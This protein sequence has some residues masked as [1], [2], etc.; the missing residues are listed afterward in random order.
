MKI[1]S[2]IFA[3]LSA[4]FIMITVSSPLTAQAEM[5][6][7]TEITITDESF[8]QTTEAAVSEE[9][10]IPVPD[11]APSFSA[12]VEYSSMGYVV[13]GSFTEFP[14]DITQVFP[15]Y[16][17]DGETWQ[18]C[19]EELAWDLHSLD[20]E[21]S[22]ELAK[23]QNQICLYDSMEPLNSYL[24]GAL[25]CFYIKLRLTKENGTAYESQ[26]AVITRENPQPVPEEITFTAAFAP[27]IRIFEKN[28]FYYYGKYQLTI[29]A[30]A[31]AQDIASFLPDTLPIE[32]Q[33]QKGKEF[34]AQVIIDCPVTW[35]PLT[36]PVLTAG[37]S[38]T[39]PDA[40]EEIIIPGDTLLN[41]P[42][43]DFRLEEPLHVEQDTIITDDV[44]LVLNVVSEDEAPTGVLSGENAGLKMAFDL[45]PTG[46]VAIQAYV[47]SD[48]E[49]EWTALPN[50]PLAEAVNAQPS[51]ASSGYT[52]LLDAAQEP[53]CS[54]LSAQAAGCE[55]E[56]FYI[57]FKIEGGVYDDCE[58]IL[59][60]PGNYE[61][62]PDLTMGGAGG[63]EN[64]AGA[65]NK[66]DSTAEGQRPELPQ[67]QENEPKSKT[68]TKIAEETAAKAAAQETTTNTAI[69]QPSAKPAAEPAP[70]NNTSGSIQTFTAAQETADKN[71]TADSPVMSEQNNIAD[72]ENAEIS[73]IETSVQKTSA[74][75]TSAQ[76][77]EINS[78]GFFRPAVAIIVF[79]GIG[80]IIITL[81]IISNRPKRIAKTP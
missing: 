79:I 19:I 16:S 58:L 31:T 5:L 11:E 55:A 7:E 38:I 3:V 74:Q 34:T 1:Y 54:Y 78:P 56:P 8:L 73:I 32:V 22:G 36:L 21:D 70:A 45:K 37:E 47:F 48:D 77:T 25:D 69:E 57:G 66:N 65:D 40:V 20:T 23:L 29:N 2:K 14:P 13:K 43:G 9:A 41:T 68:E 30:D 51:T 4:L 27:S 76:N 63:N 62:P 81:K 15:L 18:E 44:M 72:R 53:Y 28:P 12:V 35:K 39:I 10:D 71:D 33:L 6:P 75:N 59:P 17:L 60:Y 61:V 42:I 46:A 52:F 26:T 50:L 67:N 24:A 49:P 80:I 64:N